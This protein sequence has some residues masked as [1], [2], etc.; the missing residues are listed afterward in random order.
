M[1]GVPVIYRLAEAYSVN[2][3]DGDGAVHTFEGNRLGAD[4][5]RSLFRREGRIRKIEV[6]VPGDELR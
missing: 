2:V 1:C 3:E 5:S 4:W 6:D